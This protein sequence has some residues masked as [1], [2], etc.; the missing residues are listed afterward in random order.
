M[1]EK[2]R[3]VAVNEEQNNRIQ[4]LRN[5]FSTVYDEIEN[6][7]KGSRETSLALTKLE[8]AQMWAIRGI[9]RE[10]NNNG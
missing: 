1:N 2:A 4:H 8:E 6:N 7:C 5:V 10:E 9:S 3:Y